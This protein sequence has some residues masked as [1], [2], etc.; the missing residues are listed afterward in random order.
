MYI[1]CTGV[2]WV[3]ICG[4]LPVQELL[5]CVRDDYLGVM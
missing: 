2:M 4:L 5:A 1:E 3:R